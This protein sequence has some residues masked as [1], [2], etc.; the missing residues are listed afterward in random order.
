M[1]NLKTNYN[2]TPI[3]LAAKLKNVKMVNYLNKMKCKMD[4]IDEFGNSCYHYVALNNLKVDFNIDRTI[5]NK[6][7]NKSIDYIINH[8][9]TE[10]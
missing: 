10:Y 1:I 6:F 3:I 8:I 7:N 2:E 4:C 5:I 9:I